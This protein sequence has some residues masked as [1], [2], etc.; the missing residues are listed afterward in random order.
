MCSESLL[1][2]GAELAALWQGLAC[3]E[4]DWVVVGKILDCLLRDNYKLRF[5]WRVAQQSV[6]NW[7]VKPD[8]PL[9]QWF[10]LFTSYIFTGNVLK[11]KKS[12]ILLNSIPEISQAKLENKLNVQDDFVHI[13]RQWI[14]FHSSTNTW[15]Y[16]TSWR[17]V[18]CK[19]LHERNYLPFTL[20]IPQY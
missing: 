17:N 6:G 16:V 1:A 5:G 20:L 9:Q 3:L 15:V 14:Y 10:L 8:C 11:K 2:Q 4:P 13:P 7:L 12:I 18:I 19:Y